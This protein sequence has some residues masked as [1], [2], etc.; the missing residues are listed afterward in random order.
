MVKIR[1]IMSSDNKYI[2]KIIRTNLEKY[3]L[4]IPGTAYYDPEISELSAYYA[5]CPAKRAYFTAVS[6]CGEIIG[7]VGIAEFDGFDC[8][9]ELQKLYLTDS[10]KGKGIGAKLLSHAE[11]EARKMG[12]SSI[13]LETHTA[14]D[15]A[16]R[17]Y[18][19]FG[20]ISVERPAS[21]PH[22]AMNRFCMK[23]L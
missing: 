12:Y 21:S 10:A 19:K 6:E 7:G 2:E 16:V 9:A 20:Y 1:L 17:L 13:Y 8:C 18:E 23:M 3:G 5:K 11:R 22:G 14:L 15:A 4:D